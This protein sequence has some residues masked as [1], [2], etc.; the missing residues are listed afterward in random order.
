L[1]L[2]QLVAFAVVFFLSSPNRGPRPARWL[3]EKGICFCLPALQNPHFKD[4]PP[5]ISGINILQPRRVR[6][7]LIPKILGKKRGKGYLP[8]SHKAKGLAEARPVSRIPMRIKP[9]ALVTA[10]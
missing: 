4:F 5:K 8:L 7:P 3:G 6:K 10:R 9:L 1:F 2:P